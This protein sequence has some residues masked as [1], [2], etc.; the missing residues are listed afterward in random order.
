MDKKYLQ[1]LTKADSIDEKNYTIDFVMTIEIED[2]HGDIVDIDSIKYTEYMLN[3][4]VLPSHDHNAKAV[5]KVIDMRVETINGIK[6]LIGTVQFAVEEYDLAKTYWNLY[7]GGYMSAV[8]IGFIPES[9]E[10]VN[11]SFVLR[12][13]NILELSFVSIPANQLALAKQKG[14]DI[15]PVVATMD[16]ATQAKEMTEHLIAFKELFQD[17]KPAIVEKEVEEPKDKPEPIVANK[18]EIAKA[19]VWKNFDCA[20]REL[21]KTT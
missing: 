11:D 12:G 4:V 17:T 18:K 19:K 6:A 7:K 5:A 14:I 20:I 21:N 10:M 13:A 9:G 3:P 2:R 8:S 1:A 16:Y 15:A